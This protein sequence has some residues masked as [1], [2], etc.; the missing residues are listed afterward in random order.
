MLRDLSKKQSPYLRPSSRGVIARQARNQPIFLNAIKR[1]LD[2]DIQLRT[3]LPSQGRITLMAQPS[4]NRYILHLLYANTVLRGGIMEHYSSPY[5]RPTTPIEV[6]EELNPVHEVKV[7]IKTAK[8]IRRVT[9]EPQG[10]EL[11]FETL[12]GGRI[13]IEIGSFSCHQ[14][15]ALHY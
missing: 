12:R 2:E 1:F 8:P 6:V 5:I 4:Q 11:Q 10:C 14:M 3:N 9:L 15:V 13:A 7:D